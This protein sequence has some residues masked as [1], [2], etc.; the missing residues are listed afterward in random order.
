MC[1]RDRN[2]TDFGDLSAGEGRGSVCV[3]YVR[4]CCAG[5]T[6]R[7]DVIDYVT[8]MTTGNAT[9]FGNLSTNKFIGSAGV[10]NSAGRGCVGGGYMGGSQNLIDYFTID[11]TGNASDFGDLTVGREYLASMSNATR[12]VWAA[13]STGDGSSNSSTI[14]YITIA[15]T[16]NASSFGSASPARFFVSGCSGD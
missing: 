2:A 5:G 16:G 8:I 4:A 1:I 11:T 12:G 14:D 6:G 9:A 10:N 15:T 13:G 7:N 3:N